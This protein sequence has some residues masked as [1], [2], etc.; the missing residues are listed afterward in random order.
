MIRNHKKIINNSV[1]I[2]SETLVIDEQRKL[3]YLLF[4]FFYLP[5][6]CNLEKPVGAFSIAGRSGSSS[7]QIISYVKTKAMS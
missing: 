2:M 6:S 7:N 5:K 4:L 3:N 1:G